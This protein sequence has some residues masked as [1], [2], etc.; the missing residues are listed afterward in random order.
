MTDET[1]ESEPLKQLMALVQVDYERTAKFIE[2]IVGVETT[3]RGWTVTLWLGLLGFC[4]SRSLWELGVLAVVVT[5]VLALIDAYHATL[6]AQ[7]LRHAR[8]LEDIS[9]MYFGSLNYG[10]DDPDAPEE[11]RVRLAGHRFGLYSNLR[12]FQVRDVRFARPAVFFQ[13]VYP[14]LIVGGAASA[15]IVALR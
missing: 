10:D 5:A 8:A 2:S 9:A 11:I 3:I 6:Y 12:A 1:M 15:G 13:C 4:F 7:A 14:L